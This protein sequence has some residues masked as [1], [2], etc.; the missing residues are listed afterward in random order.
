MKKISW[1][2]AKGG[3][4][5][6][7]LLEGFVDGE[8]AFIK[9]GGLCVTDLREMKASDTFVSPKHYPLSREGHTTFEAKLIAHEL[10]NGINLE[11]HEA[12]RKVWED[13]HNKSAEVIKKAQEFLDQLKN[14]QV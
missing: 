9:E 1:K 4:A 13:E 12:S 10:L 11:Q 5:F 7:H 2:K 8:L 14:K 6:E 3:R